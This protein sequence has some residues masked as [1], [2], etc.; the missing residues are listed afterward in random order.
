MRPNAIYICVRVCVRVCVYVCHP[1]ELMFIVLLV[2]L[3]T[4]FKKL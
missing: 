3:F 1:S 2:L 4:F